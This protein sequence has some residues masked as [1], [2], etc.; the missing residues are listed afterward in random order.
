MQVH[1]VAAGKYHDIDFARLELL[2]L[3]AEIPEVRTSVAMDFSNVARL[4]ESRL[5][6]TYTCDL[7]PESGEVAALSAFLERGGRWLALH[8][9]N[10]ILRFDEAGKVTTPDDAPAFMEL[11][12]TRFLGHPAIEPF[13]VQVSREHELTRGFRTF[14]TLDELYLC[15]VT[16]DIDVLMHHDF[17]GGRCD[18]F[19]KTDFAA[20][21]VPILYL[22]PVGEGAVLYCSLGHCR[23]HYDLRPLANFWPRVQRCSW[24]YPEFIEILRRGIRWGIAGQG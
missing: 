18:D 22:R 19:A 6:I 23:G 21:Q 7:M 11:L 1:L 5:L 2:K 13:T 9:T 16:A 3:L 8:G 14:S 4:A 17:A 12:G 15:E 24:D 10:S 20:Q